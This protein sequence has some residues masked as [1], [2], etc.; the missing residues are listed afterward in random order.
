MR[1]TQCIKPYK[2]GEITCGRNTKARGIEKG[3]F[4][5]MAYKSKSD[6]LD[7]DRVMSIVSTVLRALRSLITFA[8]TL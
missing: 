8:K 7:K 6:P 4:W 1:R 5:L 3:K 2:N